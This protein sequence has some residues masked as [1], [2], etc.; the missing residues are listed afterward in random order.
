MKENI[1]IIQANIHN[2]I[3]LWQRAAAPLKGCFE[4]NEFSFCY[5]EHSDWPNRLW[6]EQEI[7]ENSVEAAKNHICSTS[8]N[9]LIPYWDIY[10]STSHEILEA[11]GFNAKSVQIGMSLKLNKQYKKDFV[12]SF[13]RVFNVNEANRWTE[14]YPTAF[15]YRISQE[16]LLKS[17][18]EIEFYLA[19]HRG[20][21]VGTAIIYQTGDV[22]GVHG[23]G[24]IPEM[25][26][27]GFAE[28]M[29][30]FILDRSVS[31]KASYVT[32]QASIMGKGLY[33]KLGFREDFTIKNYVLDQEGQL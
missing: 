28:E 15:G 20:Q 4:T 5:I 1:N 19:S 27:Q 31:L 2:L 17:F 9:L 30:E 23:V 12:L 32:L 10:N 11:A 25:R 26:R 16:I 3:S 29:M 22:V 21:P 14:V 6:F 33:D 24:I 8:Q 13:E 18:D 7:A